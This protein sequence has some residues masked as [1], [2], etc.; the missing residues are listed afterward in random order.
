MRKLFLHLLIACTMF[1]FGVTLS[2]VIR[3][4]TTVSTSST[5]T[6]LDNH[7][8]A[9]NHE[10]PRTSSPTF[11]TFDEQA[12][13][14]IFNQYGPA[15]TNHDRAFFERVESDHFI[16]FQGYR[17]LTREQDIREME[18]WPMGTIYLWDIERIQVL[19]NSA[20]VIGRMRSQ[21]SDGTSYS[22]RLI[23]VCVKNAN[24]WQILSTT[25]AQ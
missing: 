25:S 3:F 20:V 22:W 4:L 7:D 11:H 12:L 1:Y 8:P 9:V 15:Q 10:Q 2:K 16:L 6:A 14:E 18:S 5:A 23:N 21:F 19:G 17:K 24:G 13:L